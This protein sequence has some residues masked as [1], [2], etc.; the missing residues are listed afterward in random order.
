MRYKEEEERAEPLKQRCAE[1]KKETRKEWAWL[2]ANVSHPHFIK[3]VREL[4]GK[5]QQ[6]ALLRQRIRNIM[7]RTP[8]YGQAI[9]TVPNPTPK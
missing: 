6:M 2:Q 8:E 7:N 5:R 3:R 4:H 9:P 1:L